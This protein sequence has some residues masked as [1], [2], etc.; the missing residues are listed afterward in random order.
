MAKVY[1]M[2]ELTRIQ[3][4]PD[5]GLD[6]VIGEVGNEGALPDPGYPEHR[7]EYVCFSRLVAIADT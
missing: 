5:L 6:V 4:V 1:W 2:A 7:Q 3:G